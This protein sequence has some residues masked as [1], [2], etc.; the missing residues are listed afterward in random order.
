MFVRD[1]L[2]INS[3]YV[4][5][6]DIIELITVEPPGAVVYSV[7]KPPTEQFLLPPHGSRNMPHIVIADF[8]R[9]NTLCGYTS[10]HNNGEA[11]DMWAEYFE[12]LT[13]TQCEAAE[14]IQQYYMEERV[15]HGPHICIVKHFENV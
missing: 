2:K 8:N 9:H 14:I 4:C 7:Y 15:Q 10:A 12:K 3:I 13:H 11:V 5:E 1:G 6:E